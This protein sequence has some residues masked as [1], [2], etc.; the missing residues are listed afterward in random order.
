M[1][2]AEVILD[3]RVK[4]KKGYPVKIRVYCSKNKIHRSAGSIGVYQKGPELNLSNEIKRRQLDLIE[5]VN[6]CNNNLLNLNESIGVI[7]NGIPIDDIDTEI[8]LLEK[9]LEILRQ[10]KGKVNG[11]GLI[12][13]GNI[14]IEEKKKKKDSVHLFESVLKTF[15]CFLGEEEDIN[16]N[17]LTREVL[18]EFIEFN[19]D[20]N[21]SNASI[22][23]YLN[24]IGS[25]YKESQLRKSL[26][27]KQDNPFIKLL[28]YSSEKVNYD[29]ESN[30]LKKLINIKLEYPG[31]R[32]VDKYKYMRVVELFLFQFAIGG[33]D[34][35]DIANLKWKNIT[36]NNRIK[37]KR[38]KFRNKPN[39]GP[40][41][42]NMLNEF[43]LK[44]IQDYGDKKNERI[45]SF[46]PCPEN[47]NKKYNI[48]LNNLNKVYLPKI[49]KLAGLSEN[50]KT[51]ATRYIFRTIAGNLMIDSYIIMLL[52]GHKPQGMTYGYMGHLNYEV[53]DREHQK[54]LD[55]VFK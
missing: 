10:K 7:K 8:Q 21:V 18:L 32:R 1:I 38:F 16:M 30:D 15:K 31:I 22:S 54:I 17:L 25:I 43:A 39:T 55:T 40:E 2:S 9:R 28:N 6:Y 3:K 45:F 49:S 46:I 29:I 51:K 53:Q 14:F 34:L 48:Y 36:R 47:D 42:N 37:F 12:E 13:F 23:T 20:N 52:Q 44:V 4:S 35:A 11:I 33:H 26:N 41:V 19:K 5:E 50:L 27:I 24:K